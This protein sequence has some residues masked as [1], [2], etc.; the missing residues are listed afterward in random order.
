MVTTDT[1]QFTEECNTWREALRSHREEFNR[2]KGELQQA[3]AHITNKDALKDVEH[4]ENQ[5]EIQLANIHDLKQ[6][7]KSFN[8]TPDHHPDSAG[9]TINGII[10]SGFEK[11][12]TE[13]QQ[14]KQ[15]LHNLKNDFQRF[16]VNYS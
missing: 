6:S 4:Y 14:L 5:F 10:S 1:P 16:L 12:A 8:R 7:I 11:I 3:A 9:D 15:T 2:M 13:Y